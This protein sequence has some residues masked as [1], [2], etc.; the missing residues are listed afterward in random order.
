M[1]KVLLE[2]LNWPNDFDSDWLNEIIESV[3]ETSDWNG[4]A[5]MVITQKD[6]DDYNGLFDNMLGWEFQIQQN[7][8][9]DHKTDGQM[10]EYQISIT[11]NKKQKT[12][13]YTEM[14]LMVGWNIKLLK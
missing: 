11:D 2:E 13:F 8:H 14:C 10:V 7:K 5:K 3:N 12:Q 1:K 9:E 4:K 6:V